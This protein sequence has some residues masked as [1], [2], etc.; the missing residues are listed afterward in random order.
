MRSGDVL[1]GLAG[2]LT[3]TPDVF[4]VVLIVLLAVGSFVPYVLWRRPSARSS[5]TE[6]GDTSSDCKRCGRTIQVD[7]A[8]SRD[9]FEGMHWL[10]FHLEFEHRQDPDLPCSDPSCPQWHLEIYK[11]RLRQLGVSP[12]DVLA[13]AIEARFQ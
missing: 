4:W 10:C 3:N 6:D 11:E 2:Y 13:R 9:V 8:L 1:S 5:T 7:P 12:E